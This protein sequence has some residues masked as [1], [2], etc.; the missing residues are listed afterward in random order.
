M[1]HHADARHGTPISDDARLGGHEAAGGDEPRVCTG[2]SGADR[3][4]CRDGGDDGDEPR[5]DGD[6]GDES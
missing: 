5:S 2:N 4:H 6:D 3:R 1:I